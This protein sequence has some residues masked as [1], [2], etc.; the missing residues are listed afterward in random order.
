LKGW[1]RHETALTWNLTLGSIARPP[2][3]S[4]LKG[5]KRREKVLTWNPILRSIARPPQKSHLKG[6]KRHETALTWNLILGSIARPPQRSHSKGWKRAL[7]WNPI[8]RSLQNCNHW[9]RN[10]HYN[11]SWR[12]FF[13]L[14]WHVYGGFGTEVLLGKIAFEQA[15]GVPIL[16]FDEVSVA[17]Y[18]PVQSA[19][20][21]MDMDYLRNISQAVEYVSRKA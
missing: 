3:K 15:E 12:C 9:Y 16:Q 11:A 21:W 19:P 10:L 1:K 20:E 8:W 5:W 4:H 17:S 18:R 2:Q 13:L 7:T 14:P 6:W